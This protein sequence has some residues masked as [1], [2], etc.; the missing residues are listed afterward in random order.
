MSRNA[1]GPLAGAR[2]LVVDDHAFSV[3]L[4]K[5]VLAAAGAEAILTATDG[6]QAVRLL[7]LFNPTVVLT[8]W[9]MPGMDGLT[10]A[11]TI[12]QAE[13]T[14]DPRIDDP[15]V[16]IVLLSGYASV[17]AVEQARLAGVNEVV[18]K[19][20]SASTL[21]E[22]LA[23]AMTRARTFVV[24]EA[25]IGPDRR[26]RPQESPPARRRRV[27]KAASD[28][29]PMT[30]GPRPPDSADAGARAS[31]MKLLQKGVD[32][33]AADDQKPSAKPRRS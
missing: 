16:P 3:S 11:Q 4:I 10:L 33:L 9:K 28:A 21:V 7:R 22:R 19:P 23:A 17:A 15:Q 26:R 13:R 25:Y 8:D 5:E 29:S 1:D 18:V 14:P 32:T 2:V 6:E 12:R 20:F 30:T 27:D 24:T 31:V